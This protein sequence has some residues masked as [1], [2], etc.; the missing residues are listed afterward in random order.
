MSLALDS[1]HEIA[2]LNHRLFRNCLVD[3]DEKAWTRRIEG[4]ANNMAFLALHM[5]GARQYL[6]KVMGV[7]VDLPI[8]AALKDV[9]D[10]TEIPEFPSIAEVKAAW[11]LVSD[12]LRKA[13]ETVS[14]EKLAEDTNAPFPTGN[15]SVLGSVNFLMAHESY[16]LGQLAF[17][18]RCFGLGP[19]KY[20]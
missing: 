9:N 7:A 20:S 14:D 2:R 15:T 6:G 18:R 11:N 17:L 4:Q 19:M 12:A 10:A 3:V 8:L 16:H 1:L 5:V 13:F